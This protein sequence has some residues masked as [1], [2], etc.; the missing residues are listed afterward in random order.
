MKR[1]HRGTGL[2]G[3]DFDVLPRDPIAP[4]GLQS[5]QRG[6]FCRETRGIMLRSRSAARFTV[7]SLGVREN[8]FRKPRRALDGFTHA[9]DLDDV[10]SD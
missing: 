8:A 2:L 9:A 5:F 7:R 6:F 3:R 4:A 1:N 10:N